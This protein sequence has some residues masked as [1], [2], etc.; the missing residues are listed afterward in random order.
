MLTPQL[1]V[2]MVEAWVSQAVYKGYELV[3]IGYL[4]NKESFRRVGNTPKCRFVEQK[5]AEI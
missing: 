2:L 5:L 3:R 4:P 1:G